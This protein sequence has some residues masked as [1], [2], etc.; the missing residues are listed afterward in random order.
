MQSNS[1]SDILLT[2]NVSVVEHTDLY[3]FIS[4]GLADHPSLRIAV[5][6]NDNSFSINSVI[7][8]DHWSVRTL[9][10]LDLRNGSTL[11]K[12]NLHA[13]GRRVLFAKWIFLD[14]R[15]DDKD[16]FFQCVM[17][18]LEPILHNRFF[19]FDSM[20]ESFQEFLI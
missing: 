7:V 1:I 5:F 15:C 17:P 18:L 16:F 6:T 3:S 12:Y 11:K 20:D 10:Q 4:N 13:D 2:G 14:K 19:I 8:T 9:D